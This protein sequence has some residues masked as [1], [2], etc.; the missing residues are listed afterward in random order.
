[1]CKF[2]F[3]CGEMRQNLR[4]VSPQNG[5][6]PCVG[7]SFCVWKGVVGLLHCFLGPTV[8]LRK[9]IKQGPIEKSLSCGSNPA[10]IQDPNLRAEQSSGLRPISQRKS[11]RMHSRLSNT[12]LT[13]P[14]DANCLTKDKS[15]FLTPVPSF[16]SRE[17]TMSPLPDAIHPDGVKSL[18]K[19]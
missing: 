19:Q 9:R 10:I 4:I 16:H 2:I 17:M 14:S 6:R 8:K 11:V 1:M 13:G 15:P 12:S 18:A 3:E 7:C 5:H